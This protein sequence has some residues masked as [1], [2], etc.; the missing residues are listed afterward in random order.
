MDK[1]TTLEYR[2]VPED[3]VLERS[4]LIPFTTPRKTV[5]N[6]GM[7]GSMGLGVENF[8]DPWYYHRPVFDHVWKNA[9]LGV[10]QGSAEYYYLYYQNMGK[11]SAY[12]KI[13]TRMRL[14]RDA[15]GIFLSGGW[16]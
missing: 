10:G 8:K 2:E 14:F 1:K 12:V 3:E 5:E 15:S 7:K 4:I 11:D 16:G 6:W 9:Y 13:R